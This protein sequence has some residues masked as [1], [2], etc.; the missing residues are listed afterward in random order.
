MGRST[1]RQETDDFHPC[2]DRMEMEEGGKVLVQL[3]PRQTR[4]NKTMCL[5]TLN[6]VVFHT[7]GLTHNSSY[8]SSNPFL[9]G[10][11]H[12][13]PLSLFSGDIASVALGHLRLPQALNGGRVHYSSSHIPLA[14][15]ERH[16]PHAVTDAGDSQG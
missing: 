6:Q 3:I 14:M 13:L 11:Q 4:H 7:S 16:D 1:I 12:A 15:P 2:E 5:T 8:C 10:N 9:G